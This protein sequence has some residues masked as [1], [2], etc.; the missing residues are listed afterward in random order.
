MFIYL[1]NYL[2]ITGIAMVWC[3]LQE[4]LVRRTGTI[5]E[6]KVKTWCEVWVHFYI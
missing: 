5:D 4:D 2:I 1:S 6:Q 3:G